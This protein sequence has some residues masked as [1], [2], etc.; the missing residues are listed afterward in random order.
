MNEISVLLLEDSELDAE[1]IEDQLRRGTPVVRVERV[2]DRE[3]YVG[4]LV[5]GGHDII[6]SDFSLPGFDGRT[7]LSLARMH[8]PDVPFIFVSGV[9]GEEFAIESLKDGAVDYVLKQRLTRLPSA[10]ARAL[11]EAELLR[12][13]RMA[14][15]RSRLL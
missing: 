15:E 7:A 5:R 9:L 8:A 2:Q 6:L 10:V 12:E 3:G 13:R 11:R 14:E 4:A 1:L